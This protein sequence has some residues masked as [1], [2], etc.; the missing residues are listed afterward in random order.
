V[1]LC[2]PRIQYVCF[3]TYVDIEYAIL[4]YKRFA[5]L[6]I[7]RWLELLEHIL[8]LDY[9][10]AVMTLQEQGI[11]RLNVEFRFHGFVAVAYARWVGAFD[12][13]LDCL[14]QFDFL[15]SYHLVVA[16]DVDCGVW[17]DECD[18]VY[19]LGVEFSALGFEDVFCPEPFARYVDGDGYGSFLAACYSQDFGHVQGVAACDMVDDCPVFDFGNVQLGFTQPVFPLFERRFMSGT[20]IKDFKF[21][22]GRVL[23]LLAR[24][25]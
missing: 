1:Y 18:L 13:V 23:G 15:F 10:S 24:V 21:C 20:R 7:C 17:R 22:C 16:D 3:Q 11:F 8:L 6:N 4:R 12:D 5:R 14:R 9:V 2:C 19:F 25:I